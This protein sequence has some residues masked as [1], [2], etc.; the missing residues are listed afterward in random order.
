MKLPNTFVPDSKNINVIIETPKDSGNKYTFD[1]KTQLFKLSKILPEGLNFPLHFGFIPGTKGEDGDPLD[2]LVLMDEPSYPGNLIECKVL[3]VIKAEQTEKNGKTMRNDRLISAAVE[4][5]RYK[6]FNS[7]RDLDKYLVK[8][9]I[10]FFIT[11]NEMSKKEFKPLG[12]KGP[13]GALKLI[14]KQMTK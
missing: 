9:I 4:S 11:Y 12:N 2:V 13:A 5:H 3:G 14:K 1:P 8:E 7:I 6:D 10:N